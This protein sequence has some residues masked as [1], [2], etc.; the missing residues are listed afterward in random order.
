M[1]AADDLGRSW[2]GIDISSK[3]AELVV[4]RIQDRQGLFRDITHRQDIPRRTDLGVL[5]APQ[6]HKKRLYGQQE[7]NCAGCDHHFEARHLEVDH[8]IAKS[9]G[10]TD[11]IDNLQ[12]LCG[13][14]NRIKGNRGMEYLRSKLHLALSAS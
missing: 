4:R 1:V 10:G 7:G 2:A 8:I 14:C 5:P 9:K 11:H 12:L 3:A 6:T 13:N